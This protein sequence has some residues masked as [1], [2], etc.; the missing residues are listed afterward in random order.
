MFAFDPNETSAARQG[1]P[2]GQIIEIETLR[3]YRQLTAVREWLAAQL[4]WQR[5][6]SQAVS[7]RLRAA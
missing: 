1:S 2:V 7:E 3:R 4:P 6:V 5:A